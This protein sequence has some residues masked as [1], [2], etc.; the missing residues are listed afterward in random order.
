MTIARRRTRSLPSVAVLEGTAQ[1]LP[2]ADASVDV[3][4]ARWSYFSGP[5]ASPGWPS[6]TAW[7]AAE[8]RRS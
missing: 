7:Y 8:A 6:W 5:G 3:V 2:V 4:H 1:A